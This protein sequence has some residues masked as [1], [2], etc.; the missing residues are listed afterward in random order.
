MSNLKQRIS[1]YLDKLQ[2]SLFPFLDDHLEAPLPEKLVKLI[3]ILDMIE[4]EKFVADYRGFPGR[5]PK[6]RC[7][8]ARAFVAKAFYNIPDTKSLIDRLKS[9]KNLRKVCGFETIYS[10]PS[11]SS[12]SRT[13]QAF[14]DSQ[15]PQKAHKAIISSAYKDEIV[16]HVSKDSTAI[17]AREKP[18]RNKNKEDEEE[19]ESPLPK[20][21]APKGCAKKTRIEK[22][23]SGE[24]TLDEMINDLPV[25]CNIGRKNSSSGHMYAWIGYKLHLATDDNSVPLAAIL[26]SASLNDTQA[27]IPLAIITSQRVNSLYDLMDSGYYANAIFEHSRSLGHVP[28]IDFAAKGEAQKIEKEQELLARKNL[29]WEPAEVVRYNV[30]TSIERANS[31]LKDEFGG[32][33]VR[34]KGAV[35]VFAHLMY[36]ILAQTADQLLK[37]AT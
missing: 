1:N 17:E 33:N 7:A 30:R 6:N 13:F 25:C 12:F 29:N 5:P 19:N 20:K 8:V 32:L 24:M 35:K 27:A 31:R 11:E 3:T 15:L 2:Q 22:Q 16:G 36:G 28:I 14:A 23:A 37:L 18:V 34:V 26:S 9:D 4:I 10:I 21:R